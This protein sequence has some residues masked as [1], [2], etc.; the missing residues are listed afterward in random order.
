MQR[1]VS[2]AFEEPAVSEI[3]KTQNAVSF[4]TSDLDHYDALT[5]IRDRCLGLRCAIAGAHIAE[6]GDQ[7]GLMQLATDL[8]EGFDVLCSSFAEERGIK[9]RRL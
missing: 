6:T 5:V 3:S 7:H 8:I 2:R 4:G 9:A 1:R